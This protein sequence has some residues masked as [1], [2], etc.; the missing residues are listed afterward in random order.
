S[1]LV[2]TL[3]IPPEALRD[4]GQAKYRALAYLAHGG[5]MANGQHA[6]TLQPW[7]GPWFGTLYDISSVFILSLA[8]TSVA[9]GLRDFVP[10][11]LHRLG[12]EFEWAHRM[13]ATLHIF[14]FINLYVTL[15]YSASVTAQRGAYATSVLVLMTSAAAAT[16]LDRWKKR[17]GPW[18][19]RL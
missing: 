5:M 7:F 19:F 9:I 6:T 11:Y 3:L 16:L 12:M 14:M 13:G 1:S 8:R 2:T 4:T 10:T 17:T 18:Y 15:V